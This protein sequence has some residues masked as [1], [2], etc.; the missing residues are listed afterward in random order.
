MTP[1]EQTRIA[2]AIA[3]DLWSRD[4]L[5]RGD[6]PSVTDLV[7]DIVAVIRKEAGD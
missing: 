6:R 7:T 3:L 5:W 4:Y 2:R 1:E